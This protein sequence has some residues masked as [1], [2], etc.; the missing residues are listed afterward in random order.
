MLKV[1]MARPLVTTIISTAVLVFGTPLANVASA[2]AIFE[3]WA[4]TSLRI[5]GFA[6][7]DGIPL[8]DKPESLILEGSGLISSSVDP[9]NTPAT[10]QATASSDVVAFNELDLNV[11]EGLDQEARVS[12]EATAPPPG[13][14]ESLALTDGFLFVENLSS[15]SFFVGFEFAYSYLARATAADPFREFAF[16]GIEISVTSHSGDLFFDVFD[17]SDSDFGG[18]VVSDGDTLSFSMFVDG[19]ASIELFIL[20]DAFGRAESFSAAEPTT[21]SITVLGLLAVAGASVRR[22]AGRS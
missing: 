10:G 15:D 5:H 6:D 9:G 18:G 7:A 13:F 3:A 14:V 12:G 8:D 1:R 4:L 16:G 17:F 19:F 20:N 11:G 21:L 2:T 22:R